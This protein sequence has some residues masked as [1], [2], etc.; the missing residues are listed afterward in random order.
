MISD[1]YRDCVF[2]QLKEGAEVKFF[3]TNTN[4]KRCYVEIQQIMEIIRIANATGVVLLSAN[5]DDRFIK[6]SSRMR[7]AVFEDAMFH[8]EP[9]AKAPAFF[10]TGDFEGKTVD[11][12][13]GKV[14]AVQSLEDGNFVVK[15]E[16]GEY[17]I[18]PRR[19]FR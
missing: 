19:S 18:H 17:E 4:N 7:P 12:N 11:V 15:S 3:G 2:V 13:T 1:M 16:N 8:C 5:G 6:C 9:R 14:K 10:F